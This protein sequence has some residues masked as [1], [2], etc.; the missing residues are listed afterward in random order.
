MF[1]FELF[2]KPSVSAASPTM[3]RWGTRP[4]KSAGGDVGLERFKSPSSVVPVQVSAAGL[5]TSD[6]SQ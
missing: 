3:F 2:E 1:L 5:T 4:N 6:L